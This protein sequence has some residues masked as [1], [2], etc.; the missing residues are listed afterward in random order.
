[1]EEIV[2][3]KKIRINQFIKANEV[4]LV[5]F[6][7][8]ML[9]I[10]KISEALSIANEKGLDLVEVSNKSIP[11]LCKIVDFSKFKYKIN[12]KEKL[13]K[14][15]QKIIEIKETRIK[16]RISEHDLLIKI[17][18]AKKLLCNFK[19]VQFTIV[20]SGRELQYKDLGTKIIYRIK[21]ALSGISESD[22]DISFLGAKMFIIFAPKKNFVFN[23]K[24]F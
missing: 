11:P 19:K 9:G 22:G 8:T 20:F 3:K 15:K 21:E 7:G 1:L 18:H 23:K 5:S 10:V 2:N 4:R 13:I 17:E 24:G 14:K 6:D 12:K 16:P